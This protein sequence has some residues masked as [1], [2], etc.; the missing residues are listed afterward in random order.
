MKNRIRHII[1]LAFITIATFHASGT[2]VPHDTIYF[3][4]SWQQMLD[5][6]PVAMI[7]DP[8]FI[9]ESPYEVYIDSGLDHINKQIRENYLAFS[10]H[11]SIW[12]INSD[13]LKNRFQ[14]DVKYVDGFVPLFFNEKTAFVIAAKPLSVKDILLGNDADGYTNRIGDYYNIDFMNRRLER[15]TP[16]YL[17]SLLEDYRDLLMR[18]EGMKDYKKSEIIEEYFFKYIDRVADDIMRPY[19]VD[20]VED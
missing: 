14:G 11:D 10:M 17:S 19:I 18:Y 6:R 4:S 16:D 15:V 2:T 20:L 12:F 5:I 1:F 8:S 7:V 3:Y 9:V 13:Y